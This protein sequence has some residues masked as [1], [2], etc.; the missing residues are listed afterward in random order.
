MND[1]QPQVIEHHKSGWV[2]SIIIGGLFMLAC[3]IIRKESAKAE[4]KELPIGTGSMAPSAPPSSC[5]E[6]QHAHQH[7]PPVAEK[8]E[9]PKSKLELFKKV[10]VEEVKW[11]EKI[12]LPPDR[13]FRLRHATAEWLEFRCWNG[14]EKRFTSKEDPSSWLGTISHCSFQIRGTPG[15]VEVWVEREGT[16]PKDHKDKLELFKE[17]Q[18][19]ESKWSELVEL[20]DNTEFKIRYPSADWYQ[21]KFWNGEILPPVREGEPPT[22]WGNVPH[23]KFWIR[24]SKGIAEVWIEK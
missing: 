12:T 2:W 14:D 18:V 22:Y 24:G 3:I 13:E 16:R 5:S 20:P 9:P 10:E 21:L 8:P 17:V 11:S 23:S 7:R 6:C 4:V 1:N 15:F 19:E